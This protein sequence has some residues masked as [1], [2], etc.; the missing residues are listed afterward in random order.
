LDKVVEVNMASGDELMISGKIASAVIVTDT[1]GFD[2]FDYFNL[3]RAVNTGRFTERFTR[4][5][6]WGKGEH[7]VHSQ[8][9]AG[10]YTLEYTIA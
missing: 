8:G 2:A 7:A 6:K 3:D 1:D 5:D 4:A 10:G 9:G